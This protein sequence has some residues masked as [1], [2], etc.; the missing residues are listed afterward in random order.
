MEYAH[1][2]FPSPNEGL[3][4]DVDLVS[5]SHLRRLIGRLFEYS[6]EVA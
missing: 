6:V 3:S 2:A 5:N 1:T 4:C